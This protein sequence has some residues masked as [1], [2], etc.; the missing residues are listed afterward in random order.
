MSLK[1]FEAIYWAGVGT[2]ECIQN[3]EI[4]P[5]RLSMRHSQELDRV[6]CQIVNY[7]TILN[8]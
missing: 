3:A 4:L 8:L 1:H 2:W 5:I 7:K 6:I